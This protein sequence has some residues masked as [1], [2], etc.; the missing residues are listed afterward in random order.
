M[1]K[2]VEPIIT[3]DPDI[4]STISINGVDYDPTEAQSLI[5]L[6]TK[7]RD[8]EKQWDTPVDK[9][10]PEYGKTRETL[11]TTV[12]ERDAARK[13]LEDF[14]SKQTAG[15]ETNVDVQEAKE[16]AR[17]LGLILN[18]DFE[19]Q[20]YIK[21]DDLPG[22]FQTFAQQQEE[23][24]KVLD[25][26]NDLEKSIDGSDGRPAFNKKVVLAYASAYNIPDLNAAYE[27]MNKTQLDAW[28][29]SQVNSQKAKG[30]KTLGAGGEKSVK[31]TK[32]T[33]D[34]VSDLLKET[35]YGSE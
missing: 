7:T 30:L 14:K 6:G 22:L 34:N 15:T 12:A 33:D 35:L 19:K 1:P 29:A 5:D 32:V 31:E 26:A 28:K 20:G 2:P 9:V 3:S 24:R 11:N 25:N 8:L 4:S 18:E 10:W 27:D 16:A 21:K 23:V 13:E 17:K